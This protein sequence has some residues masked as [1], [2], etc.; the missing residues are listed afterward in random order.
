AMGDACRT[1]GERSQAFAAAVATV[2][3]ALGQ[4]TAVLAPGQFVTSSFAVPTPPAPQA[5]PA[6]PPPTAPPPAPPPPPSAPPPPPS[7]PP[8]RAPAAAARY[9]G[10]RDV[11]NASGR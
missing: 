7:A 1:K 5:A 9:A 11:R 4:R 10:E 8:P 2:R 6:V 3:A